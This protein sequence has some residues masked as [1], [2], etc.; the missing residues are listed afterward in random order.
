MSF[1]AKVKSVLPLNFRSRA[2]YKIL[3]TYLHASDQ[4]K[5]KRLLASG[6]FAVAQQPV[7]FSR[8]LNLSIQTTPQLHKRKES[9]AFD[10]EVI[11]VNHALRIGIR[12]KLF[13]E[14]AA[15][16]QQLLPILIGPSVIGMEYVKEML[17]LQ[18][19]SREGLNILILGDP[20]IGKQ[21]LVESTVALHPIHTCGSL[22]AEKTIGIQ[23]T[24]AGTERGILAQADGG[25]C[26]LNDLA[27][28]SN[29]NASVLLSVLVHGTVPYLKQG[30]LQHIEPHVRVLASSAPAVGTFA[31]R[32]LH[33]LKEQL[34]FAQ[35]FLHGFHVT[36]LLRKNSVDKFSSH[37]QSPTVSLSL[38]TADKEFIRDYIAYAE[39]IDV[40]F[41]SEF[42]KILIDWTTK[43]KEREINYLFPITNQAVISVIRLSQ[44]RARMQL[45]TDVTKE[46]VEYAMK[47]F[48]KSLLF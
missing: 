9:I 15:H 31:I 13:A 40:H 26:G 41:A 47:L 21:D 33:V 39:R 1:F 24:G 19:F 17:T 2:T 22:A 14:F 3:S 35:S 45:R 23:L 7:G 37:P 5:L 25:I 42:Q 38:T 36:F 48:E 30:V 46:D 12:E 16:A 8:S 28:I 20:D 6:I 43:L 10:K 44:A 18:L 11:A 4:K 32:D 34:T 29:D 27:H